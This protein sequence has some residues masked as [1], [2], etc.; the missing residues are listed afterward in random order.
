M[1]VCPINS[2]PQVQHNY[3]LLLALIKSCVIKKLQTALPIAESVGEM[4]SAKDLQCVYFFLVVR[5][6]KL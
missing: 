6:R 5:E 1:V 2:M 4:E 3:Q